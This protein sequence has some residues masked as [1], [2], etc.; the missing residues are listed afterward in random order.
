MLRV[1]EKPSK[2]NE[3]L[4]TTLDEVL[5]RG[6]D[7]Y[8]PEESETIGPEDTL[9]LGSIDFACRLREAYTQTHLA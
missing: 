1:V 2:E 8:W 4:R 5:R 9:H 7:G 6:A 3:E